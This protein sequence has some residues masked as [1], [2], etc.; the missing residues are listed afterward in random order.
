MTTAGEPTALAVVETRSLAASGAMTI[1]EIIAQKKLVAQCVSELMRENEHY[2]VIP[3]TEKKDD[4]GNDISKRVLL[5]SGADLL[6]SLFQLVADYETLECTRT[7]TLIYYRLKCTLTSANSGI[8]RGSGLGSCNSHEEKYLRA[9][10]K[11]CPKCN[12]ETVLRSKLREGERGEPGW[13]C[14]AKKGGC[15]ANFVHNAAEIVD[16]ETGIKDPADLDNTILKMAAKRSRV[17]AVLT[18]TGA[19][20]FFTQDVEDLT[21]REAEYI[22]PPPPPKASADPSPKGETVA[23]ASTGT[24]TTTRAAPAARGSGAADIKHDGQYITEGQLKVLHITR[25]EVGGQ[26][27]TDGGKDE[28]DERSL[29]RSKVLAVYRDKDGSRIQ[30]SKQLSKEQ[31][32]HLIDRLT[33]YAQKTKATLEQ[34][35]AETNVVDII[36]AKRKPN[37]MT[38]STMA[39]T[40]ALKTRDMDASELCSIFGVD[41]VTEISPDDADK[42]LALV[43]AWN[44]PKYGQLLADVTGVPQ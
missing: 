17:D 39:I 36:P 30:S 19:S 7:P 43:F 11:K 41:D 3:G 14:W 24:T 31:A 37:G 6:C 35:D 29:W 33:R 20:D 16:Q 8:R 32:N 5:K 23:G 12:K 38:A 28:D 25:R 13:F 18:V 10:G 15:G 26:Y 21:T 4:R 40:G 22:P 2:G 27:C 1:Q 34:R 44:T 9:A 42:A